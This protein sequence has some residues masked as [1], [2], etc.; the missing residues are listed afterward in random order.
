M[1]L[2]RL[3]S[4]QHAEMADG[5]YIPW[6]LRS[7][8]LESIQPHFYLIVVFVNLLCGLPWHD[9]S[10][11][12]RPSPSTFCILFIYKSTLSATLSPMNDKDDNDLGLLP[13]G[14]RL[15]SLSLFS[16]F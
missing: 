5:S 1:S 13:V 12:D 15:G 3:L 9:A 4:H 10:P 2:L 16:S 11:S 6:R 14:G 8:S 7:F